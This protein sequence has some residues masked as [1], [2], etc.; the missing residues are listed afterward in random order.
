MIQVASDFML[1]K[2]QIIILPILTFILIL[3][4]FSFWVLGFI[5]LYSVGN[6]VYEKGLI[7][8]DIQQETQI[9]VFLWILGYIGLWL[10]SFFIAL[11]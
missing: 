10:V 9:V 11:N 2:L 6:V 8:G 3:G 4:F 7:F 5:H 1:S